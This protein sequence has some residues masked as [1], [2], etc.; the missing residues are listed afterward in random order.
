MLNAAT[1]TISAALLLALAASCGDNEK[2]QASALLTE[3][4]EAVTNGDFVRAQTLIDSIKSAYPRV[5]DVRKEALHLHT[6]VTEGLT[7]QRL[8]EVETEWAQLTMRADSLQNYMRRV[9]NPLEPYFIAATAQPSAVGTK[10]GLQARM[11]PEGI[12]YLV[13]TLR[14][15]PVKSTAITVSTG[16]ESAS[17]PAVAHDGERNDRSMG[18]EVIT[19][20]SGECEGVGK[21]ISEHRDEPITL[22]FTGSS[23]YSMKMPQSMVLE[24]VRTYDVAANLRALRAAALEKTKLERAVDIARTQAAKTYVVPDSTR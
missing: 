12:F 14:S 5:I 8:S 20:M 3:A 6:R 1:K 16:G 18:A 24:V 7:L 19:F 15:K 21:F 22:T 2:E 17:T 4:K 13:S 10:D 23:D 9:D 11:S